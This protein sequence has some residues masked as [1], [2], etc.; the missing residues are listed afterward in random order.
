M[1]IIIIIDIFFICPHYTAGLPFILI[2]RY[3]KNLR[4]KSVEF[5]C[6]GEPKS[7]ASGC[8]TKS[9]NNIYNININI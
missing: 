6:N 8:N 4:S 7:V 2:K 1:I 9:N 3:H 5:G